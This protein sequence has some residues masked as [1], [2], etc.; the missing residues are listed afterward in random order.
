[1]ASKFTKETQAVILEALKSN[2]SI[3]SAATRAG[4]HANTLRNWINEGE[5]G[6]AEFAEFALEAA[7]SRMTMKDA[8]VAAL[9]ETALDTMHPQQTKAAHQ[10][11]TN[12]FPA[13]FANVRHTIQH[14]ADKSP[15]YD[16]KKLPTDE[17]RA[18]VRTLKRLKAESDAEPQQ[19]PITVI[20][21]VEADAKTEQKNSRNP[22]AN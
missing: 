15:E 22:D 10:L 14:Q 20:E 12:L 21:A 4:I 8:I 13:E 11:L 16:L 9:L 1:M 7:E 6:N 3:P 17:L 18:F 5:Q 2:P 19:S